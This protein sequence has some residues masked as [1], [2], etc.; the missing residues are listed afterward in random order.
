MR[1]ETL[2]HTTIQNI[3][4]NRLNKVNFDT[5]R[6]LRQLID[7]GRTFSTG[8]FQKYYL[9]LIQT[10]LKNDNSNYFELIKKLTRETDQTRVLD[11]F[12]NLG[13]DSWTYNANIIREKTE[14]LGINIPWIILLNTDENTTLTNEE[15][16]IS[17]GKELGINSFIIITNS[18]LSLERAMKLAREF[19]R[20]CFFIKAKTSFCKELTSTSPTNYFLLLDLDD[21]F[22]L[23]IFNQLKKEK[24]LLGTYSKEM[25][26]KNIKKLI[27]ENYKKGILFT[28]V[29]NEQLNENLYKEILKTRNQLNYPMIVID[30]FEDFLEVN[31]IISNNTMILEISNNQITIGTEKPNLNFKSYANTNRDSLLEI[32]KEAKISQQ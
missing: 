19:P 11:F 3:V 6:S 4:K 22:S 13:Y 29:D 1:K 21:D 30:I 15:Y 5:N 2:M 31:Q 16:I 14:E 27:K 8:R 7:Y 9:D 10:A 18:K 12:I 24:L 20:V 28:F 26:P 17:Q 23:E 25:D 32:L